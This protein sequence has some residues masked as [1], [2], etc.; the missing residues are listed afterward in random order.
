MKIK[1]SAS[2]TDAREGDLAPIELD[3]DTDGMICALVTKR[4]DG[5]DVKLVIHGGF[6]PRMLGSAMAS[7]VAGVLEST[8][9]P[10]DKLAATRQMTGALAKH[11]CKEEGRHGRA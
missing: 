7:M 4:D 9:D 5:T 6:T 2:E 1:I 11:M 10:T 8:S 3:F